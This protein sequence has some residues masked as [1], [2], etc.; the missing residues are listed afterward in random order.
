MRAIKKSRLINLCSYKQF[1]H[2]VIDVFPNVSLWKKVFVGPMEARD[3]RHTCST[4]VWPA[5]LFGFKIGGASC[6]QFSNNTSMFDI[7]IKAPSQYGSVTNV[8]K[9]H[10]A[11]FWLCPSLPDSTPPITTGFDSA[12]HYR[13][14]LR[15]LLT[16]SPRLCPGKANSLPSLSA[17]SVCVLP[18]ARLPVAVWRFTVPA[19]SSEIACSSADFRASCR[20]KHLIRVSATGFTVPACSSTL[21]LSTTTLLPAA[22]DFVCSA[23]LPVADPAFALTTS[24]T[25]SSTAPLPQ[26]SGCKCVYRSS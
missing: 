4:T 8:S 14:W 7:H 13:F 10:E 25:C 9:P 20:A 5:C 22:S 24:P 18:G 16:A 23:R 1:I 3:R 26:A 2:W 12:H 21:R 6:I 19:S 17:S 15:L 11:L